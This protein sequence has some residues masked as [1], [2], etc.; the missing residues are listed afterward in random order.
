MKNN[1]YKEKLL[2]VAKKL[3]R[4]AELIARSRGFIDAVRKKRLL[5]EL[6]KEQIRHED[7][8]S[9]ARSLR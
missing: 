7:S 9:S 1:E 5:S 6:I 4:E 8:L 3:E 2:D